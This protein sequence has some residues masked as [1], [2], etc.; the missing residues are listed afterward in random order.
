MKVKHDKMRSLY[1]FDDHVV[2]DN[3]SSF[4]RGGHAASC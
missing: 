3:S 1:P 2:P 4:I